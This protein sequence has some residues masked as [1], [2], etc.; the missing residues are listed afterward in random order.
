MPGLLPVPGVCGEERAGPAPRALPTGVPVFLGYALQGAIGAPA[1]LRRAADFAE[2]FGPPAP[3]FLA[4]AVAAFFRNGG[5]LCH[6][7]RLDDA[8]PAPAAGAR[9][10]PAAPGGRGAGLGGGA[11][12]LPA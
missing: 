6:V 12:S 4:V 7:I 2:A 3:S 8:A 11:G 5:E 9:R 1:P 10:R